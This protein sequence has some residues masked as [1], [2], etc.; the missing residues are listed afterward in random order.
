MSVNI[1]KFHSNSAKIGGFTMTLFVLPVQRS[2]N[3]WANEQNVKD[4][5]VYN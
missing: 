3:T 2:Y 1:D 4:E 5:I